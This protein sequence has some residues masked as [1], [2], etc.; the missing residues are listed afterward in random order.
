MP[1][2]GLP[3]TVISVGLLGPFQVSVNQVPVQLT[4]GR[5]RILLAVLALSSGRTVAVDR[6]ASSVWTDGHQ[7][8]NVRRSIQT[9]IG[10]L[11]S[12][13]GAESIGSTPAGYVLR[14]GSEQ[15][16][17]LRFVG[18]LKKS[19]EASDTAERTD[20]LLEALAL[21]RGRPFDGVPS[22]QLAES[23][24]PWLL[25]GYLTALERRLDL[26]LAAGRH[27]GLVVEL[28]ELVTRHPLRESLWIRLIIAL[29]RSGR[30][31]DA[32]AQYDRARARIATELGVDP[33]PTLQRVHADLLAG[34]SARLES[35]AKVP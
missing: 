6:L 24:T 32:L 23:E 26:D 14:A 21:W 2:R 31:A 27:R 29:D 25:E 30:R 17:A 9:Y 33:D 35:V 11:R 8:N 1:G 3:Q 4:A 15:V 20:R 16:D 18:L 10:R 5:L 19:S 28:S 13:L 7:P 34:R 12:L 22:S